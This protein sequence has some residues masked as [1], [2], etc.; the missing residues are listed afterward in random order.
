MKLKIKLLA[1][2][3]LFFPISTLA[4]T[5]TPHGKW[6]FQTLTENAE[7]IPF[8]GLSEDP[9]FEFARNG[10]FSS[11]IACNNIGGKYLLRAKGKIKFS[12]LLMT[13]KACFGEKFKAEHGLSR[14]LKKITKYQIK[15]GVL[16]LQDESGMNV[17]A[18]TKYEEPSNEP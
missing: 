4:Q 16:T 9:Y 13:A 7:D 8:S 3:L 18:L 12:S 6:S 14:V 5:R 1:L 11:S 17:V 10:R 15:G 2:L